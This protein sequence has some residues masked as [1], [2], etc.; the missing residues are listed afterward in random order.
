MV[1]TPQPE[2]TRA[3]RDTL[4]VGGNAIDAAIATALVQTVVDPL[5]CGTAGFG[6]M[7]AYLPS[8]NAHTCYDF[9]SPAPSG[10][11]PD[12]WECL[13]EGEARDGYG[14]I[15][16]GNVNDIGYQSICVPASLKAFAEA[17]RDHGRLP[18][19][20]LFAPAIAYAEDGWDVRPH[21]HTF[22]TEEATMGRV[23]NSDRIAFTPAARSLY[24]RPDG[25]PKRVGDRV[26]NRD[27]AAEGNRQRRRRHL[28][29]WRDY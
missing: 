21:V 14:F 15:L 23:R 11:R 27:Y 4:A 13:I 2:A 18:W 22:W 6:S 20:E 5:M 28:L 7:A 19:S 1:V 10:V 16:K 29:P 24:C 26:I 9:H 17:H 8:K 25:S 12:M 3:G